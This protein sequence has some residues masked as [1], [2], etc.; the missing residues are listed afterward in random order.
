MII[1]GCILSLIMQKYNYFFKMQNFLAGV[2]VFSVAL[3]TIFL[4]KTQMRKAEFYKTD[5]NAVFP[6]GTSPYR[7]LCMRVSL[8]EYLQIPHNRLRYRLPDRYL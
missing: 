8:R 7:I 5:A 3:H 2:I 4:A 6:S 1:Y